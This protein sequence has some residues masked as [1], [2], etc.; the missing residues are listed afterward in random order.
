MKK[1]L[2]K[3]ILITTRNVCKEEIRPFFFFFTKKKLLIFNDNLLTIV[4][5]FRFDLA[6]FFLFLIIIC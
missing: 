5:I 2:K 6:V 4:E 1:S 3:F